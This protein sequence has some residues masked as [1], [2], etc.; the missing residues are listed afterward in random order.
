MTE[1]FAPLDFAQGASLVRDE[2]APMLY[3][4]WLDDEI[5]GAGA[6]SESAIAEARETLRRWKQSGEGIF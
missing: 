2:S 4:V 3:A 1:S 5:I 6:D